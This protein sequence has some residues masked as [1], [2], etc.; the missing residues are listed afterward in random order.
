MVPYGIRRFKPDQGPGSVSACS[1]TISF[2]S[3]LVT[4]ALVTGKGLIV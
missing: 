1:L 3:L 4:A 2:P